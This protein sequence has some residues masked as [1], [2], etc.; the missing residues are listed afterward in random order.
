MDG[1]AVANSSNIDLNG[2]TIR[3]VVNLN[4]ALAL[5]SLNTSK[6][7][8]IYPG[9]AS[10]YDLSDATK[11]TLVGGN[12]TV[13]SDK[14]A[15]LNLTNS[16]AGGVP[17]NASGFNAGS[18]AYASCDKT[19]AFVTASAN[20]TPLAV[21]AVFRAP[22]DVTTQYLF[23]SSSATRPMIQFS[24]TASGGTVTSGVNGMQYITGAWGTAAATTINFWGTSQVH[25]RGF[26][27]SATQNR[28]NSLCKM[29]GE[30]AE[31]IFFTTVPTVAQMTQIQAYI[32]AR[33]GLTFP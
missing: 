24:S 8:A 32:N 12:V 1:I 23:Y 2:G 13:I 17:Y 26:Q 4:S 20:T 5:G 27:F 10:W 16:I 3:D 9:M 6:I 28:V 19:G 11:V 29:T 30:L 22:A 18:S 31:A 14:I 21:V 25:A 7:F 15:A 33:Y